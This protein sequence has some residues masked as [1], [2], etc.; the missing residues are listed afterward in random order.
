MGRITIAIAEETA[1][2]ITK[3][4]EDKIDEAELAFEEKVTELLI[5]RIPKELRAIIE[6]YPKWFYGRNEGNTITLTENGF[7]RRGVRLTKIVH[8]ADHY[9][10]Q[11]S[12]TKEE[13]KVL[14][15]LDDVVDKAT[16][17]YNETY[18][19]IK[20]TLINL[21]T[22]KR[23][24]DELPEAYALLPVEETVTSLVVIPTALK[25]TISC[26]VSEDKKC[27]EKI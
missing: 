19:S 16:E 2:K 15:K 12:V 10:S 9:T 22:Y 7:N 1:L 18:R 11:V 8:F 25:A 4:L 26:L 21:R 14:Y 6:K 5:A 24:K 3:P 23:V 20:Q 13:A 27:L 17:K